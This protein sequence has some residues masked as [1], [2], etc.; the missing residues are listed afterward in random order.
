MQI[1]TPSG[2]VVEFKDESD[3]TYG[4]RRQIQRVTV[5]NM[6]IDSKNKDFTMTGETV[7][8]IQ[9]EILKLVIKSI[10]YPEGK[11]VTTNLLDEVLSWKQEADGSAVYEVIDRF[12]APQGGNQTK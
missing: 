12:L 5:K 10:T 6:T 1:T 11:V 8:D 7:F 4:D 9:D 3:L 2:Y